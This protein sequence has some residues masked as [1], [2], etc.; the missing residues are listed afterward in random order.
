MFMSKQLRQW[1][2][3]KYVPVDT[4]EPDT[5]GG[6]SV[7]HETKKEFH[8]SAKIF[9]SFVFFYFHHWQWLWGTATAVF[10]GIAAIIWQK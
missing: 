5:I 9:R 2:N 1:Y 10:L 6:M 7:L 4:D 3:G 8:W